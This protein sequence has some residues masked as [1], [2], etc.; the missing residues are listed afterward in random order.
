MNLQNELGVA[1][2]SALVMI[3][4]PCLSVKATRGN[5]ASDY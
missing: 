1:G 2:I 4:N 3:D 5:I